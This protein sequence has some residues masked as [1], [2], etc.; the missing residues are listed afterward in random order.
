MF[1]TAVLTKESSQDAFFQRY[2]KVGVTKIV[3]YKL[4]ETIPWVV[5]EPFQAYLSREF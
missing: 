1:S 4:A 3:C 5:Y 2:V